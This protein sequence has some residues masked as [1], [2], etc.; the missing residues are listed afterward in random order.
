VTSSRDTAVSSTPF[1]TDELEAVA[2]DFWR[3]TDVA[4]V[5]GWRL[6]F[7]H[8][9]SGRA[10]SVWPNGA[11]TLPLDEKIERA[12]E[13]YRERGVPVLFQLTE[14]ARPEGLEAALVARAYERGHGPVS[15]E[16]AALDDVVERTHGKAD[17]SEQVDDAWLEL[18]AGSRGFD[19][20][21]VVRAILT[22]GD[23]A[24]ASVGDIA[25]GR[26]VAVG[27]WL[28][29]T[30][31]ATVPQARRQ[32]H[33]R[34]IVHA[35][36]RWARQRGCTRAMIQTDA[37]NAAARNLYAHAGFVAHHEYRYRILR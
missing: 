27:E 29:I 25:V 26:G 28:G 37:A 8:G 14:A 3:A 17:V 11:G 23:A 20:H 13:W 5:D 24:F 9:I 32:G 31:M 16:I 15:V 21:D 7:A 36:A 1:R 33:A 18:W 19:N 34:A 10:N 6:R 2:Y 22:A 4:E 12:E 30:S 35:L